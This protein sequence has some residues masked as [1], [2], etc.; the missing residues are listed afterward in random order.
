MLS[1]D[2]ID[3]HETEVSKAIL[4]DFRSEDDFMCVAVELLKEI[5]I[6]TGVLINLIPTYARNSNSGWERDDAIVVGLLVRLSKLQRAVTDQVCQKRMEIVQ[7]LNSCLVET[8]VNIV[9]LLKNGNHQL[10]QEYIEYSL[11]KEKRF[12]RADRT[13]HCRAWRRT[14]DRETA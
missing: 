1:I 5:G 10:Y 14:S 8:A 2:E 3:F 9:F 6:I 11:G 12:S 13:Q 7:I 4:S